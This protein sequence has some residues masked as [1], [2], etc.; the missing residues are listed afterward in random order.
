[1]TDIPDSTG[2]APANGKLARVTAW[3]LVGALCVLI[4]LMLWRSRNWPLL[5]DPPLMHYIAWRIDQGEA[6]YRDQYD[7][8]FAG[9]FAL[10][11]FVIKVLGPGDA[12]WRVFDLA[13]LAVTALLLALYC[14]RY[15]W[16]SA[17]AAGAIFVAYHLDG[18]PLRAGQRDYFIFTLVAA[19]GLLAAG[20]CENGRGL[21]RLVAAGALVGAAV[22][23][24]PFAGLFWVFLGIYAAVRARRLGRSFWAAMGAVVLGG[25]IPL[26]A[27]IFWIWRMG[28]LPAFIDINLRYLLP[29]YGRVGRRPMM[30][31]I[32]RLTES[33]LFVAMLAIGAVPLCRRLFR[34]GGLDPARLIAAAGVVYGVAHFV[35][36]GKGW[37]YHQYPMIGFAF[38][39]AAAA[40]SPGRRPASPNAGRSLQWGTV[41]ALIATLI[42][43]GHGYV[44][45]LDRVPRKKVAYMATLVADIKARTSPR[46]TV[47]VLDT[48]GGGLDALLRLG[49]HQPTAFIY[50]FHFYH[51]VQHPYIRGLRE[52]FLRELRAHPPKL[53]IL[54]K[55]VWPNTGNEAD[56]IKRFP[57]LE[58]WLDENY[59]VDLDRDELKYAGDLNARYRIYVQKADSQGHPGVR[60]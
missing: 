48:T 10:H 24:K 18:G 58:K 6:P 40:D 5:Q 8:N 50:D 41:V 11:Y 16:L 56:R 9:A 1:M 15:G 12:A 36:Q 55:D 19:S 33:R 14:R 32:T 59:R 37:G 38:L 2:E 30:H 57:E 28:A 23:L 4:A 45:Y 60:Q 7:M 13:W 51:H 29:L 49:L 21:W 54:F 22:T 44:N 52:R 35:L 26:A 3:S 34:R 25:L 20:F 17:V 53:V 46:D 42:S 39:L 31:L 43:V 47:Q 27:M